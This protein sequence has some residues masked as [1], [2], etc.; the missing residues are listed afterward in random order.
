MQ[1]IYT[2][3]FHFVHDVHFVCF[4]FF[5]ISVFEA[6]VPVVHWHSGQVQYWLWCTTNDHWPTQGSAISSFTAKCLFCMSCNF[7]NFYCCL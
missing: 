1:I 7:G 5:L 3:V 2:H 4:C 6:S